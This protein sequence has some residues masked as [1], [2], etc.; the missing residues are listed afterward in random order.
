MGYSVDTF[1]IHKLQKVEIKQE[2]CSISFLHTQNQAFPIIESFPSQAYLKE[3]WVQRL[4]ES[5]Y[6]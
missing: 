1:Q 2:S 3:G 5:C 6:S 4:R